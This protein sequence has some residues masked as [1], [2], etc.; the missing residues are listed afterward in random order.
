MAKGVKVHDWQ[1]VNFLKFIFFAKDITT[2][3]KNITGS[4]S[5]SFLGIKI[6]KRSCYLF[7]FIV[8]GNVFIFSWQNCSRARSHSRDNNF[9]WI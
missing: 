7:L 2:K 1:I 5:G 9:Y 4:V 6:N 3:F 8:F